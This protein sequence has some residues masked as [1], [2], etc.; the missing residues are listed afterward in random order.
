MADN[1]LERR[2][3]ELRY[4]PRNSTAASFKNLDSLLVQNRSCRNFDASYTVHPLQ[5]EAIVSVNAKIA[6][7][8]NAGTLRFKLVDSHTDGIDALASIGAANAYIV[9]CS[10][11]E[12]NPLVDIDLGISL[13]SMCLKAVELGLNTLIITNFDREQIKQALNLDHVPLAVLSVGKSL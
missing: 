1:Y 4:A 9:V 6:F 2:Q 7:V 8:Q 11:V 3:E 13:Q 12:E 5:L 10:T